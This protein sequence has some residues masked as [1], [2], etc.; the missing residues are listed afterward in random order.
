MTFNNINTYNHI[1][2]LCLELEMNTFLGI[3]KGN[4]FCVK[5]SADTRLKHRFPSQDVV[6]FN[7]MYILKH[8]NRK[9]VFA[10]GADATICS[11]SASADS[12]APRACCCGLRVWV[13]GVCAHAWGI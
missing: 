6:F 12:S 5:F 10:E 3:G 13:G 4:W 2:P 11:L 8:E 1:V 9:R 7:H